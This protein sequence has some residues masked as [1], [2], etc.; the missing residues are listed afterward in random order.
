MRTAA[1]C[2][3]T[4]SPRTRCG[5]RGVAELTGQGLFG[6]AQMIDGRNNVRR[7]LSVGL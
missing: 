3:R 5:G 1:G 2:T 6:I 4:L 7:L